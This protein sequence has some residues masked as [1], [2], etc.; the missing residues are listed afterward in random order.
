MV[1]SVTSMASIESRYGGAYSLSGAP[2]AFRS[3]G[4][5]ARRS[6]RTQEAMARAGL[7]GTRH[8]TI[9]ATDAA[10]QLSVNGVRC[11]AE[12]SVRNATAETTRGPRP[13]TKVTATSG[14][15]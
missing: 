4:S 10:A 3:V 7:A 2:Y 5:E 6:A 11:D 1:P 8:A 9:P 13:S 14:R 12:R 15:T